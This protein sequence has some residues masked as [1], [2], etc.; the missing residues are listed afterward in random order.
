MRLACLALLLTLAPCAT[1]QVGSILDR[2]NGV[3]WIAYQFEGLDAPAR[4]S[5]AVALGTTLV[6][7][8][9]ALST[10]DAGVP[11][12][13]AAPVA[14]AALVIG[15]EAGFIAAADAR[16][17]LTG[18]LVRAAAVGGTAVLLLNVD[19]STSGLGG[20]AVAG[21]LIFPGLAIVTI[22]QAIDQARLRDHLRAASRRRQ[23]TPD[24]QLG[25]VRGRPGRGA[26]GVVLTWAL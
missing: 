6:V 17:G 3:L 21:L 14:L 18:A 5:M 16:A 1:A 25:L 11:L 22:S 23:G 2:A 13:V 19:F 12:A 4:T 8:A 24:L 15:P 20:V 26:P 10:A 7:P 9:L